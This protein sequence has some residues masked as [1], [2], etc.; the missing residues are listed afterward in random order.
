MESSLDKKIDPVL[1]KLQICSSDIFTLDT[2]VV[3]AEQRISDLE[4]TVAIHAVEIPELRKKLEATIDKIDDL[5]NRSRRCNI[6]IVGLPEGS[7]GTNAVSFMTSWLPE[8]VHERFKGGAVKIDRCHRAPAGRPSPPG[9]RP[10]PMLV[11][12]HNFQDKVRIMRAARKTQPLI[13]R[14]S[15]ISI[16]GDFSAAVVKKRE[17]FSSTKQRFREKGI[18]YAMLYPAVLKIKHNGQEKVFKHPED[19]AR[20]LDGLP[21]VRSPPSTSPWPDGSSS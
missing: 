8:L 11:K 16:F 17:E 9:Q 10:R 6:R 21:S 4:D 19:A 20:Y 18:S 13:F 1:Q 7:E 12:L 2:R 15:T 14:G 5:E 3:N